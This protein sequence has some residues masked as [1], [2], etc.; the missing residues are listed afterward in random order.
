MKITSEMIWEELQ[1]QKK[2]LERLIRKEEEFSIEELSLNKV[3]KL[4]RLNPHTIIAQVKKGN[5]K[6]RT[7]K[8][9][10]KRKRY[11]FRIADIREFQENSQEEIIDLDEHFGSVDDLAKKVFG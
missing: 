5:L 7:Y 10:Q 6:A 3:V 9:N 11:R 8:D 1:S 4:L 2:M